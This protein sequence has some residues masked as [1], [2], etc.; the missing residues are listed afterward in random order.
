MGLGNLLGA[1]KV[2][3]CIKLFVV[4]RELYKSDILPQVMSL[5]SN[6]IGKEDYKFENEKEK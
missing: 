1:K 3:K 5:E 2:E 4:H 6:S